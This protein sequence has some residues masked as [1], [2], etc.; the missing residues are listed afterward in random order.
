MPWKLEINRRENA[1]LNSCQAG[2]NKIQ[3]LFAHNAVR[4]MGDTPDP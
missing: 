2:G 1:E 4:K 3:P